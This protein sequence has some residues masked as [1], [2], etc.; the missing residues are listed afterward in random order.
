[1][2][3]SSPSNLFSRGCDDTI[4]T[5]TPPAWSCC[6]CTCVPLWCGCTINIPPGWQSLVIR[7]DPCDGGLAMEND[8]S[9]SPK[10]ISTFHHGNEQSPSTRWE[11]LDATAEGGEGGAWGGWSLSAWN[12]FSFKK[13]FSDRVIFLHFH[14]PAFRKSH[15]AD[16]KTHSIKYVSGLAMNS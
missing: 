3:L 4:Q 5:V 6:S 11:T 9:A 16:E 8:L 7:S 15:L 12:Y 1:M 10:G 14:C 13:P 2:N